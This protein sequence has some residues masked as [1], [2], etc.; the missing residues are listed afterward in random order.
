M[1]IAILGG[2]FNPPHVAHLLAATWTLAARPID[3]VWFMPVGEHAFGKALEPFEHRAQMTRLM[4]QPI[5][6]MAQVTDV[7]QRL[8]GPNRTIDTLQHLQAEHPEHRFSLIIGADILAERHAWKA[9]DVLESDFGFH[10]LGREGHPMPD[11]YGAEVVLPAVSSTD[12]RALLAEGNTRGCDGLLP[13]KVLQYIQQHRLY[14]LDKA[15]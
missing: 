10:I 6:A 14:G 12:I 11:G 4:L 9:W 1:K 3:A 8:G 15:S 7:E 5:G 13:A 2:S